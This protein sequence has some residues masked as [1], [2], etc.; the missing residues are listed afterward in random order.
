MA[1]TTSLTII[2]AGA[3]Y[4]VARWPGTE[5]SFTALDAY[6]GIRY[7]NLSTQVNLDLTGTLDFSD[8]R[9]ARFDRS[10]T[11]NV[12]DSGTL[13][14]VDPVIGLRLRHQFTPSQEIMLKAD[15]GGFGISGSSTFSWQVA[16]LYSYTWQFDGYA[17][18]ALGG[19]RA[20]STSISFDSGPNVSGLN[21]I[22]G[23]ARFIG[24]SPAQVLID[25][26]G[27]R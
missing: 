22:P 16:A 15:V 21:L 25:P 14:W 24:F 6:A 10:R 5:R 3:L 13:Q 2:E 1:S 18:A 17:I 7:W 23:M 9:L 11:I 8:P 26:Q 20:L 12:A 19:Y 4:E 27:A